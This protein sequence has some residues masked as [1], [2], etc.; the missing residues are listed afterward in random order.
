MFVCCECRVLSVRGL[1]WVDHSSRGVVTS[2][3][4]VAVCYL[5]ISKNVEAIVRVGPQ[6]H[7]GGRKVNKFNI[8]IYIY[9]YK[10]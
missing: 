8:Y 9:I 4:Y 7:G 6:R 5:Q 3:L 1:R 10:E 2:L